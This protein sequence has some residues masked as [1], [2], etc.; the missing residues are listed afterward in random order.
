MVKT[1]KKKKKKPYSK[2]WVLGHLAVLRC[3][4]TQLNKSI[5]EPHSEIQP[6]R[7]IFL[8]DNGTIVAAM[9]LGRAC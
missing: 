2:F 1:N 7:S 5:P 9:A 3:Y 4:Y 8:S 6:E